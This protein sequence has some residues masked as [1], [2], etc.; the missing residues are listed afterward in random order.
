MAAEKKPWELPMQSGCANCTSADHIKDDCPFLKTFVFDNTEVKM[1][2]RTADKQL[3]ATR[4]NKSNS[5]EPS[6]TTLHEITPA[7]PL[8]GSWKKWVRIVQLFEIK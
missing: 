8:N 4:R 6:V 1:T 5:T 2:G 3:P 7:D